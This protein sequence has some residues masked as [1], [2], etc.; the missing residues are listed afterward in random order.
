MHIVILAGGSG[1][2]LWPLSRQDL[3]KQFLRFGDQLSLLQKTTRRFLHSSLTESISVSTNAHQESHV[4]EQLA[5]IDPAQKTAVIVE[6]SSRNT[7][8]AIAFALRALEERWGVRENDSILVLPSDHLIEPESVF[9]QYL[10]M[11]DPIV[12][13]DQLM[14]FGIRPNKP[15]T[16]FGYIQIG[17][18]R[19]WLTYKVKRFV[20]KPNRQI[21]EKYLASGDYYWNA[22]MFAFSAGL[23]W[24]KLEEHAPEIRKAMRGS[25]S[26]VK[27]RF[28]RIPDLSFDYAVLEKSPDT[29]VC[30]LPVSWSDVGCW[31]SVYDTMNKDENQNVQVGNVVAIDTKNSLIFGGKRL[32]STVGLED[33]LIVATED[34]TFIS[35]KGESQ[36]VKDIVQELIKIGSREGTSHASKRHSWGTAEILEEGIGCRVEKIWILVGESWKTPECARGIVVEGTAVLGERKI[37]PLDVVEAGEELVAS[38]PVSLILIARRE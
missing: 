11:I 35:K 33:M 25:V 13:N 23:F 7:A 31:D 17:E 24:Q 20:E 4:R 2:R 28:P 8:P 30:P 37:G 14:I 26:E 27:E 32:I 3:P 12:R 29:L 18:R 19:D 16:G 10:E 9:L 15:E 34:A 21:A 22:G 1:T 5:E 38:E 6:P 36:K